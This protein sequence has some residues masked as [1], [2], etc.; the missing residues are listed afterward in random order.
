M[1]ITELV[2]NVGYADSS[3]IDSLPKTRLI[4]SA[5]STLYRLLSCGR[6]MNRYTVQGHSKTRVAQQ[7]AGNN[8]SRPTRS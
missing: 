5:I 2:H 7:H 8:Y 6:Q 3:L 1:E 4:C